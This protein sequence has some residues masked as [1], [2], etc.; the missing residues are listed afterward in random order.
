[1]RKLLY[2]LILLIAV[3]VLLFYIKS[4]YTT[5]NP[6]IYY[7]AVILTLDEITPKAD[8][9]Y[10]SE[11]KIL[12]IG[13]L[14][15]LENDTP[16]DVVK[17][18]LNGETVMPGFI[19]PHTHFALSM[20]MS[21]MYDLSGFTHPDNDSVWSYFEEVVEST[22]SGEWIIC[23]G[24]D[25]ILVKD[26]ILPTKPYLDSIAPD[27]P[28]IIFSQSLHSY[29]ADSKAFEKAGISERKPDPSTH[30]Y[31]ERDAEG[32]FTGLIV[33]QEAFLPFIEKINE[34][35][36][37]ADV[38]SQSSI[39]V[40]RE[41][42]RNGNT[43]IVSAGLTINDSKPLILTRHLSAEKPSFLGGLLE[44]I[45]R[46]PKR[47][48]LPRH[49]IYM[50]YDKTEYLPD[51][52]G[53]QDDFYDI[54][55]VKHWYDG[56]P[57]IGSM[58]MIEPYLESQLTMDL[59]IPVHSRG[60][61]LIR[62]ED[63]KDFIRTY[64]NSGWQIAIHTQ[65]DAAINEVVSAFSELESEL[66]YSTSRHRLEHCLMLPISTLDEMKQLN[67]SPSFHI[68]HLYYYG[69][70]LRDDMLGEERADKILPLQSTLNQDLILTLHADQPMFESR[71]FRLIQTAVERK[72]KEGR[73]IN[74]DEKIELLDAIKALTIH[75]AWQINMEDK[76]GSLE[77]G[78]YADFIVIDRN[79]FE[80]P[81]ENL[82][83]VRIIATY[84][85]GNKVN[86]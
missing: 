70:A 11:G 78:K 8:A 5:A 80:I 24:M 73:I 44:K 64:H 60:K 33:E 68:N 50:R 19:D 83:D 43:T 74:V 67:I 13:T 28:V 76:I 9:M 15:D 2:I 16:E 59:D 20:Y 34:E 46:L 26:L 29:W 14:K 42:A 56:S 38:L 75:A 62:Y 49:F 27:N 48:P 71:P 51:S 53:G 79:P 77:V 1:M 32:H 69:E 65:G 63:L 84:V 12:S 39:K 22:D 72:T 37:T 10:V 36:I 31:Y 6:T 40:M 54:I 18:N 7:N 61:A 30:S 86:N 58:Y 21:S 45:G 52:K 85:N 41:Y 47:E 55:G 66:D 23:K 4:D 82:E 3:L 17:V 81:I 25:P 35:V 57:Y